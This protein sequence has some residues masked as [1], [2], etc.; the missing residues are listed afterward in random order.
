VRNRRDPTRSGGKP[1]RLAAGGAAAEEVRRDAL[2]TVGKPS[3][4]AAGGAAA[5][6]VRRDA[7]LTVGKPSRLAP[8]GSERGDGDQPK[9]R[10]GA[11]GSW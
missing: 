9:P 8:K 10:P 3:R 6:E 4:L 2:L 1:S 11:L 7:L 5:E